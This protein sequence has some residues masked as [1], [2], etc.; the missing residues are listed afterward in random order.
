MGRAQT[1]RRIQDAE[2]A[3]KRVLVR[4]DY[5]VPMEGTTI[6]DDSRIRGS[7][8]TLEYLRKR[9]AIVIL[10][11]HLGR[12]DGQAVP[13]L[14]LDAVG[15]HLAALLG[16]PVRKL[17]EC[18][19]D[20]VVQAVQA[21]KAGDVILLENVR[22]HREE[23]ENNAAF[24]DALAALADIYVDDAFG[25]AHRAHASTVGVAQRRPAYA[26]LLVQQ[27]VDTLSRLLHN[28]ER[29]YV[30]IVGGKK[31]S[32]KLGV[33]RDL[34]PRVDAILIG[35]GVAFTFL[36]ALGAD[37]GDSRV[38]RD[39]FSDIE[40]IAR[41]AAERGTE[42]VLPVDAVLAPSLTASTDATI[43]D[44]TKIGRGLC[45]FDIGPK[46]VARFAETIARARS[47]AWAGPMGAFE[48]AAFSAGTRGVAQ[49]VASS[50]A[51]SVIGGGE[52]GEAIEEMGLSD[53][54]SFISTGGGACLSYLRGKTLPALAV[55]ED[56]VG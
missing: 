31:A 39:L 18:V 28:P 17:D 22:F 25:T 32:D 21:A 47:I 40:A 51:F 54:I 10:A 55:L 41:L 37:V 8:P 53:K 19:G 13:E 26:G 16:C 5:N 4:V 24:S 36:A 27:E 34:I 14:R 42:I 7:L 49:A 56:R 3:G 35:G 20:A 2:V 43:G 23:E 44:A 29:P 50:R 48:T 30:A 46:T 6:K 9:G 11:T 15:A 38:D 52:T 1:I 12:P 33:L 45:G